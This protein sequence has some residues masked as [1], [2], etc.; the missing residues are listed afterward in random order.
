MILTILALVAAHTAFAQQQQ[1]VTPPMKDT[2]PIQVALMYDKLLNVQPDLVSLM[3]LNPYF[4]ED[5]QRFGNEV[6]RQQQLDELK[7]MYDGFGKET[8]FL[9]KKRLTIKN[10]DSETKKVTMEGL[11]PDDP[12][13]FDLTEK[14]RY[15]I[16][17]RNPDQALTLESPYEFE[18]FYLL[19]GYQTKGTTFPTEI[20][21]RPV[22]AD[23][24]PFPLADGQSVKP[25]IADVVEITVLNPDGQRIALIKRFNGWQPVST[26][27]PSLLDLKDNP[28]KNA[29]PT[30]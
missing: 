4:K 9:V 30:Q 17:L 28:L 8:V 18:E 13:I 12:F 14:D 15:G 2:V 16:F 6:M 27:S 1:P 10:V 22:A 26:K 7:K 21:V 29:L 20:V 5:P 3:E 11:T 25:V 24:E 23:K 19:Y